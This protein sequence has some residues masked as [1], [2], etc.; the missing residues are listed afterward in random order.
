MTEKGYKKLQEELHR[1]KS[2]ERPRLSKMIEIARAHGDLSENAEYDAAKNEQ[3][4]C[5]ARIRDIEGRLAG[6]QVVDIARL[7]GEKIVFGATVKVADCDSGDERTITIVG[8]HE[9]NVTRGLISYL[10]P[11]ARGLIGKAIYDTARVS[12]PAGTKEYEVL[13][14]TFVEFEID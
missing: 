11:L 6:A 3:G 4:L 12:L 10:S 14:V 8:E 2:V 1:L 13:E 7:S 9:A 5:E